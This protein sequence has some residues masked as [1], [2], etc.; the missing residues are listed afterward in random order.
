MDGIQWRLGPDQGFLIFPY[1]FHYYSDL[2]DPNIV[3]L[4]LTFEL[5]NPVIMESFRNR[6]INVDSDDVFMDAAVVPAGRV[7]SAF[8]LTELSMCL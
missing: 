5:E 8:T 3:W 4:I 7:I 6:I 2:A 1:Q